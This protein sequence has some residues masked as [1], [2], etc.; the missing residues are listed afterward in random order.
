MKE[1]LKVEK[2]DTIKSLLSS[3][4]DI[5]FVVILGLGLL[6]DAAIVTWAIGLVDSELTKY[7][8]WKNKRIN[9]FKSNNEQTNFCYIKNF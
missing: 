8:E 7:S 9:R 3:F 4:I 5:I 1:I 2:V 6:D